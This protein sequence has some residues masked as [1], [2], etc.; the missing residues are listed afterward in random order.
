ME[1]KDL[2]GA[3]RLVEDGGTIMRAT[4]EL[5]NVMRQKHPARL[6]TGLTAPPQLTFAPIV[7]SKE[8]VI[9]AISS[10]SWASAGGPDGL[11]P[12]HLKQL[13]GKDSSDGREVLLNALLDFSNLCLAGLVP[14]EI[15]P[16]FFGCRLLAFQKPDGG[17]RPIAIGN[18]LRRMIAKIACKATSNLAAK[19]L[20]PIQLGVGVRGGSEIAVHAARSFLSTM[21][22]SDGM[23]KL[24]FSNA[25]NCISRD[26]VIKAV[27]ELIPSLTPLVNSCYSQS[28][29]LDFGSWT[30]DSCEGVQQGDPLGPL[31]FALAIR[32]ISHSCISPLRIWYLDDC[33]LAGNINQVTEDVKRIIELGERVG[34]Q[35]NAR[36]CEIVSNDGSFQSALLST[37]TGAKSISLDDVTLLGAGLSPHSSTDL[38]RKIL[39]N[40]SQTFTK[41]GECEPHDAYWI[42]SRAMG[43]PK[44]TYLLRTSPCFVDQDSLKE[45]DTLLSAGLSK[46]FSID[47]SGDKWRQAVLPAE[48]GGLCFP[49]AS[50]LALPCFLSSTSST[51]QNVKAIISDHFPEIQG[52]DSAKNLWSTLIGMDPLEEP[53]SNSQRKWYL[54]ASKKRFH[55]LV[56]SS[57]DQTTALRLNCLFNAEA[58]A[59]LNGAPSAKLRTRLDGP[60]F[61]C[62]IRFRLGLP[63]AAAARC[64]C[65]EELDP[66]GS[67]ALVCSRGSGKHIRH[68]IINEFV[69]ETFVSAGVPVVLEP[70]GL[71][72][73]DGKR[74]DGVTILPFFNGR[75]LSWDATCWNPLARS[76]AT[77]AQKKSGA[78]AELAETQKKAKYS[79]LLDRVEFVPLAVE[80]TG[81]VGP[82]FLKLLKNL[83]GR[84]NERGCG[85]GVFS[86]LLRQLSAAI[87]L[88]N[89]ACILELHGR[90]EQPPPLLLNSATRLSL[91]SLKAY[92]FGPIP[93]AQ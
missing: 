77:A 57:P 58:G 22:A 41:L 2:R 48:M 52:V 68:R 72:R 79:A 28:A 32:H 11:R 13:I 64:T 20:A 29:I 91:P 38:L 50:L 4:E 85:A 25:F 75:A 71:S 18:T 14:L 60:A 67:H 15:R 9:D 76:N 93:C 87:Q 78:V 26:A 89:A 35:L 54:A 84:I 88:G 47:L 83:S 86:R 16:K 82:S 53:A 51:S 55:E 46:L 43:S 90:S 36:K 45:M 1:A 66:L 80:S 42:L 73:S 17:S 63:V 21:S 24:D 12:S 62:A 69:R 74:P 31:L 34:L 37:L 23:V 59:F 39:H 27:A 61:E 30:I 10:F 40:V 49:S 56:E 6:S 33:S 92:G 5:V 65:G 81:A 70:P 19:A 7:A 44:L 3:I 8:Q